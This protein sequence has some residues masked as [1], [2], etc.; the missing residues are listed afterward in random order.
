MSENLP[1]VSDAILDT[2]VLRFLPT[3]S[4]RTGDKFSSPIALFCYARINILSAK[5]RHFY[6]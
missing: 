2:V 5:R 6:L 1:Q 3:T 4:R